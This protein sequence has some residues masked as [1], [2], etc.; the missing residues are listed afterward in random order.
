MIMIYS[1]KQWRNVKLLQYNKGIINLK[2]SY[3]LS[4]LFNTF[5]LSFVLSIELNKQVMAL[6]LHN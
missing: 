6:N 3:L 2:V 5:S 1:I 4:N